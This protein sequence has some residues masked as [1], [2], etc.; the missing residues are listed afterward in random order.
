MIEL[1]KPL[2]LMEFTPPNKPNF[3]RKTLLLDLTLPEAMQF[4]EERLSALPRCHCI[5]R[6]DDYLLYCQHSRLFRFPDYIHL[7]FI[8]NSPMHTH[9]HIL[10]IAKYGYYDFN[11]NRNRLEQC[12][13]KV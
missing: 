12:F 8:S 13:F 9:V 10:S 11:V 5:W 1:D 4:C 7:Q 2:N 6:E 3:A